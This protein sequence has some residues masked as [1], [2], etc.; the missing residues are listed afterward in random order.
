MA[1]LPVP[2]RPSSQQ[3]PPQ[4]PP[5]KL[6]PPR[7]SPKPAIPTARPTPQRPTIQIGYYSDEVR[8]SQLNFVIYGPPGCGK[9]TLADAIPNSVIL[10]SEPRSTNLAAAKFK[11]RVRI[12]PVHGAQSILSAIEQVR[13]IQSQFKALWV[14]TWS[15]LSDDILCECVEGLQVSYA[16]RGKEY[17]PIEHSRQAYGELLIRQKR[18]RVHVETLNIPLLVYLCHIREGDSEAKKDVDRMDEPAI[19]GG[20]R[21]GLEGWVGNIYFMRRFQEKGEV[22]RTF[23]TETWGTKLAKNKLINV[24][25][26]EPA[27]LSIVL[28]KAGYGHLIV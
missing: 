7:P 21:R 8:E 13:S 23:H 26:T 6:I 9:T 2:V 19:Q 4:R 25:I 11:N 27:N 10:T 20:F 5:Q 16:R 28:R 14:D 22:R 24:G 15:T 12:I 3:T 1:T 17:D 18:I